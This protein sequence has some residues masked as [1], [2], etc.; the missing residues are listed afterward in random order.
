MYTSNA[1]GRYLYFINSDG[2]SGTR[3]AV[4]YIY[5]STYVLIHSPR[6]F[7]NRLW[8]FITSPILTDDVTF[9]VYSDNWLFVSVFRT[10]YVTIESSY[11][12]CGLLS[13]REATRD[14]RLLYF[15]DLDSCGSGC[16]NYAWISGE[17]LLMLILC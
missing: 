9:W 1:V 11:C 2:S 5:A 13:K 16:I 17:M 3:N 14:K 4:V 12:C 6:W 15:S 7:I 8:L 10:N